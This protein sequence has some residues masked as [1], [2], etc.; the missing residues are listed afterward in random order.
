MLWAILFERL[1]LKGIHA[2]DNKINHEVYGTYQLNLRE[3]LLYKIISVFRHYKI[4]YSPLVFTDETDLLNEIKAS[5]KSVVLVSVHNGFAHNIKL[6]EN[7]NRTVS[8]IGDK[9]FVLGALDRSGILSKMNIINVDKYSLVYLKKSVANGDLISCTVDYCINKGV[10][11]Y[12]NPNLFK[13]SAKENLALYFTKSE[14]QDSGA[15]KIMLARAPST[16]DALK[17]VQ[18]YIN[19]YNTIGYSRKSLTLRE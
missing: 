17:N 13:F 4:D 15:V 6:F 10:F 12:I 19:F 8:T 11:K 18:A 5:K 16:D 2:Q 14:V 7:T 3:F 1:Y 9:S